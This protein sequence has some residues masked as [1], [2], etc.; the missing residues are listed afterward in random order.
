MVRY[1]AGFQ[2]AVQSTQITSS[3]LEEKPFPEGHEGDGT[4]FI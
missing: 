4:F 1:W 3:H 2:A